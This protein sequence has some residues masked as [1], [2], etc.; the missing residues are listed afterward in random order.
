VIY[1]TDKD[2]DNMLTVNHF[3]EVQSL[4]NKVTAFQSTSGSGIGDYCLLA[5]GA[6]LFDSNNPLF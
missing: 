6:C 5:N 4:I 3:T 1:I 2:E